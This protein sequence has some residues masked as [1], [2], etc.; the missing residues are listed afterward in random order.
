MKQFCSIVLHEHCTKLC[1][2]PF[3][4]LFFVCFVFVFNTSLISRA[5]ILTHTEL[6]KNRC[7][8]ADTWPID[9]RRFI[10][11]SQLTGFTGTTPSHLTHEL[12]WNNDR[13]LAIS[14]WFCSKQKRPFWQSMVCNFHYVTEQKVPLH[15]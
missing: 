15:N 10:N 5:Y 13:D 11:I 6:S 14:F 12:T 4:C 9:Y 7:L 8:I 2:V 3:F 1:N